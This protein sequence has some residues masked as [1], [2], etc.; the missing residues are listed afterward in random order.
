MRGIRD[1]MTGST[2]DGWIVLGLRLQ[3]LLI[4]LIHNT[5][6]V[7]HA[8]KSLHTNPLNLFP[9]AFTIRFLARINNT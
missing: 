5:V 8:L 9:L 6:A 2:S 7:L 3:S 1:E 4:T